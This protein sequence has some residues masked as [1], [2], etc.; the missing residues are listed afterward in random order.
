MSRDITYLNT[1]DP[2][3][4][5][6]PLTRTES[7]YL[8]S[9]G[10]F[11]P[12]HGIVGTNTNLFNPPPD[13]PSSNLALGNNVPVRKTELWRNPT[14]VLTLGSIPRSVSAGNGAG[15]SLIAQSNGVLLAAGSGSGYGFNTRYETWTT[16]PTAP[17]TNVVSSG[18][19][20]SVL[21]A[22]NGS[23]WS[24]GLG[25]ANRTGQNTTGTSTTWIN[26]SQGFSNWEN[27]F[28]GF[29]FGYAVRSSGELYSW[30]SNSQSATSQGTSTGSTAI[31]TRVG[32]GSDWAGCKFYGIQDSSAGA[33]SVVILKTNGTLWCAGAQLTNRYPVTVATSN[34]LIPI[35]NLPTSSVVDF[36][37]GSNGSFAITADGKLW[38]SRTVNQVFSSGT[39]SNTTYTQVGSDSDWSKCWMGLGNVIFLQKTDGTLWFGM[40]NQANNILFSFNRTTT[41]PLP[42]LYGYAPQELKVSINNQH[43]IWAF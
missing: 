26:I 32:T 33:S 15:F 18:N 39:N 20:W 24:T 19:G 42:V 5:S 25:T 31:P 40:N 1:V 27:C 41:T 12:E 30:G 4:L 35:P 21:V 16:P 14:V 11:R 29:D 7:R 2:F 10:K 23:L 6:G 13:T 36:G 37:I 17:L 28:A 34:T 38:G 9:R 8:E 3:S 22:E 43:M